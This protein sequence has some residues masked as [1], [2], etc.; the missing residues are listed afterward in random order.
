MTNLVFLEA[1]TQSDSAAEIIESNEALINFATAEVDSLVEEQALHTSWHVGSFVEESFDI[2]YENMTDPISDI[3]VEATSIFA[4]VIASNLSDREKKELI[5]GY[6]HIIA[7]GD[8]EL[9]AEA[10]SA[11]DRL[12]MKKDMLERH[13][14]KAK[15]AASSAKDKAEAAQSELKDLQDKVSSKEYPNT[16]AGDRA[17]QTDGYHLQKLQKDADSASSDYKEALKPIDDLNAQIKD[18][19]PTPAPEPTTTPAA[20]PAPAPAAAAPA[21][22]AAAK[23]LTS[24]DGSLLNHI[25]D[26]A[27][28]LMNNGKGAVDGQLVGMSKTGAAAAGAAGG[29]A[30]GGAA[31]AAVGAATGAFAKLFSKERKAWKALVKQEKALRKK[32]ANAAAI[33]KIEHAKLKARS[34]Y[35]KVRNSAAKKGAK[36]GGAVGA[37]G[38]G[39]A[40]GMY[41]HAKG[42]A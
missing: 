23:E 14:S 22:A 31:G 32:G 33:K 18:I 35:T 5:E 2:T 8:S 26:K 36:I 4:D 1:A 28:E 29:A 13:L 40:G 7:M 42:A 37:V 38:G 41:G 16:S 34:A 12:S 10:F 21:P 39:V 3:V 25:K 11:S 17:Q 19:S 27:S 9:I 20:A 15:D 30:A 24:K 6:A